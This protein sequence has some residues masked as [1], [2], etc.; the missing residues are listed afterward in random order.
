MT[1]QGVLFVGGTGVISSAPAHQVDA[2]AGA[3]LDR[4]VALG[5]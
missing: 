2:A 3:L 5:R 4:L 1:G